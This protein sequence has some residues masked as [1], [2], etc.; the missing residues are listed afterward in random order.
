MRRR[1]VV[2]G[3]TT[4]ILGLSGC[5]GETPPQPDSS[6]TDPSETSTSAS[7]S[8]SQLSITEAHTY[9]HAIRLNNLGPSPVGDI[10]TIDS[11]PDREQTVTQEALDGTYTTESVSAWLADFIANTTYIRDESD[12]YRL[13]ANLP[14]TTIT[15]EPTDRDAVSGPIASNEEYRSAVTYDG[16]IRTGLLRNTHQDGEEL[17][18]VWPSLESFLDSYAAVEYR[19]TLLSLS[20]TSADPGTPYTVTTSPVSLSDL[21][22]EPVWRLSTASQSVQE[23]VREAATESGLYAFD[24]PQENVLQQLREHRYVY[25]DGEFHTTYIEQTG[26]PP[27]SVQATVDPQTAD[28]EITIRLTLQ[29]DSANAVRITSGAPKPFGVVSYHEQGS[30]SRAGTLWSP[31][32]EDSR[33]VHTD[34]RKITGV[35]AIGITTTIPADGSTSRTFMIDPGSLSPGDYVIED[36]VGY[37]IDDESGTVPY[38]VDFSISD[39]KAD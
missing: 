16:L 13:D 26:T 10:P 24:S 34:D 9:S 39:Y 15:A 1:T 17:T 19:G 4:A 3:L 8:S 33:H 32:Y 29:N 14:T 12:Y 22:D 18:Y 30:E 21:A 25:V 5:L 23:F 2:T 35:N 6:A 20:V 37:D 28:P 36:S 11:L 27:I 7:T 38:T 31:A